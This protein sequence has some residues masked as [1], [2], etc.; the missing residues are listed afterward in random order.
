MIKDFKICVIF[1]VVLPLSPSSCEIPCPSRD[2]NPGLLS[3]TLTIYYT[4]LVLK[5]RIGQQYCIE[6]ESYTLTL[7]YKLTEHSEPYFG[8]NIHSILLFMHSKP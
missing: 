5:T 6:L 7:K 1:V 4:T 3:P 8:V 2:L